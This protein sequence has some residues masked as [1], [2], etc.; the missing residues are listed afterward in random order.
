MELETLM[1]YLDIITFYS[2][3]SL[4]EDRVLLPEILFLIKSASGRIEYNDITSFWIPDS[5]QI[6]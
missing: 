3:H 5:A 1:T 2:D 4:D 6:N